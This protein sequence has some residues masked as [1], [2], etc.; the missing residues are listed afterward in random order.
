MIPANNRRIHPRKVL[1]APA[2]VVLPGQPPRDSRTWD[3]GLDGMSLMSP[4]PIPPGTKCEVSFEVPIGGKASRVTAPVK[5]LY[6]SFTGDEGFK[7]GT[8]F[9]ELDD[10]SR[11][12]VKEFTR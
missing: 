5:V 11:D 8:S 2:T 4:K 10:D 6:C 12:A 9:G 7:V 3:V 1:R